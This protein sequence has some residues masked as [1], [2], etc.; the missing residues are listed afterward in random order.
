MLVLLCLGIARCRG[1]SFQRKLAHSEGMSAKQ[2]AFIPDP[3]SFVCLARL[4]P[5]GPITVRGT[6]MCRSVAAVLQSREKLAARLCCRA[7]RK[8][9]P[10]A[11]LRR[12]GGKTESKKKK[13]R[14]KTSQSLKRETGLIC[15]GSR[16]FFQSWVS[17]THSKNFLCFMRSLFWRVLC[18]AISNVLLMFCCAVLKQ[19]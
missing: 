8:Q 19:T 12:E 18:L 13:R 9:P 11:F 7:V 10:W 3:F 4:F 14:A 6:C 15:L 16:Y 1:Q 17:F 5:E 2:S